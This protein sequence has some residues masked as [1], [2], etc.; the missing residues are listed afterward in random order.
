MSPPISFF[1]IVLTTLGHLEFQMN[2]KISLL[3]STKKA[4]E[5]LMEIVLNLQISLGNVT[6]LT[7]LSLLI[8]EHGLFFCDVLFKEK[9]FVH[10]KNIY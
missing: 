7:M 2:F 9:L 6:I 8:H 10:S 1:T 3:I 5:I 4:D